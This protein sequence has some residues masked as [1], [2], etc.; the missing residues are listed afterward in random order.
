MSD[1]PKQVWHRRDAEPPLGHTISEELAKQDWLYA[2]GH[3][4][5]IWV[6]AVNNEDLKIMVQ[7]DPEPTVIVYR[8][9]PH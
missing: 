1:W 4:G 7:I 6:M 8:R 5:Q 9:V 2:A 3:K